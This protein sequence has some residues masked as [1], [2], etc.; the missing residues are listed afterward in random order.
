MPI[1]IICE[2]NPFHN[3][4]LYHI[5]KIKEK[6]PDSIIILVVNGLFLER[7]EISILSYEDKAKIALKYQVDLVFLLPVLYGVQSA[8][9]FAEKAVEILHALRVQK[10]IFGSESNDISYLETLARKQYE[11]DFKISSSKSSFPKR[12][13]ESLNEEQKI[14][15]NDLLSISYIKALLKYQNEMTFETIKRTNQYHDT[16]ENNSIISAQNIRKKL[17]DGKDIKDYLPKE[18]L[19]SI[20]KIEEEKLFPFLKYKILTDP[21]LDKYLDVTE[22]LEF[23]LQKSVLQANSLEEL[24]EKIK[25]KR[26][27]YNRQR[28]MLIHIFL[29]ILKKDAQTPLSYL[30]LIGMNEKGAAYL[31]QN[32][33]NFLLPLKVDKKSIPYSY[34]KKASYL[35]DLLFNTH[36]YSFLIQNKPYKYIDSKESNQK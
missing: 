11:K 29:G 28:R 6:Y 12:M 2:Y 34:E 33:K 15:P 5:Q 35:Y 30:H 23:L 24:L 32:R 21:H 4:H 22:G 27:T 18:S 7:G 16:T 14:P 13:N 17:K 1:G 19:H 9:T 10:I 31:N 8:D 26:Y 36:T 25:S 3:G 20:K